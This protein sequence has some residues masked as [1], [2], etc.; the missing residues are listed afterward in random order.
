VNNTLFYLALSVAAGLGA[1]LFY[2]GGLWWTVRKLPT[3]GNPW[4]W[5]V[6]SFTLRS[7]ATLAVFYAVMGGHWE[8][9]LACVMGFFFIRIV[10]VRRLKPVTTD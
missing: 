2:F 3:V 6:G 5:T 9:L 1:G 7:A 10:M 4:L 8:R